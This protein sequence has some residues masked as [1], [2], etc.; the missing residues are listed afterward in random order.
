M[1]ERVLFV[2]DDPAVL[3]GIEVMLFS[4]RRRWQLQFA[5]SG[6]EGLELIGQDPPDVVVADMR[7][8]AMDG[9][10]FLTRVRAVAPDT[11]R[12]MLTGNADLET[13]IAAVNAGNVFRFLTKPCA[14]DALLA[15]VEAGIEQHRLVTAERE[16]LTKT[17]GGSTR[18]LVELLSMGDPAGFGQALWLRESVRTVTETIQIPNA[19]EV[20]VGAMLARIGVITLP[21]EVIAKV[22]DRRRLLSEEAELVAR[23]P[24]IGYR[25][26]RNIP[27]L[28]PV[29]RIV[30]YQEKRYDGTGFPAD[31]VRGAEIPIGARLIKIL[32]DLAAL[33]AS[34]K[35]RYRVL[36]LMRERVGW[37]DLELLDQV[38]PLFAPPGVVGDDSLA[39]PLSQLRLGQKLAANVVGIDGQVIVAAGSRISPSFLE[40]IQNVASLSGINEPILVEREVPTR[41]Q[42]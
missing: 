22:R 20:T 23:V 10:T 5:R 19:W 12:V 25:L 7:M 41:D 42:G 21:P 1:N 40:R 3:E 17:L 11:V 27:R 29:A 8:P 2:D 32:T 34:E 24:E 37:Y 26:L 33:S 28:E 39:V 6:R 16:L 31:A 30:L 15:A 35:A 18:L 4:Q 14:S 38:H 13:A 9:I 36:R